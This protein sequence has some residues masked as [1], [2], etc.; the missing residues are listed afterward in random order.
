MPPSPTPHP[1]NAALQRIL[2]QTEVMLQRRVLPGAREEAPRD[3][4][5]AGLEVH[6]S[7]WAEWTEAVD[8]QRSR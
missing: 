7:T 1:F 8:R 2:R 3:S 5:L 4:E 6:E